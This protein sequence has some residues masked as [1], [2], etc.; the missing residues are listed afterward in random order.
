MLKFDI[1]ACLLI[2]GTIR[3]CSID[4]KAHKS[5][6]GKFD[7]LSTYCNTLNLHKNRF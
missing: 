4:I 3:M 5:N 7:I 2:N 6:I 1:T